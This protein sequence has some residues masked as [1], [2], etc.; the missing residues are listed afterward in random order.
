[1]GPFPDNAIIGVQ[2][3]EY[4][5]P[6]LNPVLPSPRGRPGAVSNFS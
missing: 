3:M 2:E 6:P 1:M 4:G 5:I